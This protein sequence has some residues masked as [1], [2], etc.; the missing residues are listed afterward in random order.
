MALPDGLTNQNDVVLERFVVHLKTPKLVALNSRISA[1]VLVQ[2]KIVPRI[3]LA[4]CW[5]RFPNIR[6]RLRA[7]TGWLFHMGTVSYSGE[8]DLLVRFVEKLADSLS[9]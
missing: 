3:Q 5:R 8:D 6:I 7:L 2:P 9:T 1:G 4:L